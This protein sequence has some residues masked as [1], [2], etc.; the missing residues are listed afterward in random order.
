MKQQSE[1]CSD[2]DKNN[3]SIN[4]TKGE[5]KNIA[6]FPHKI[7]SY[8][9]NVLPLQLCS[10]KEDLTQAPIEWSVRGDAV[11]FRDFANEPELPF[12]N[13]ILLTLMAPGDATVIATLDGVEYSC[14]IT[15][16]PLRH[17]A[18][19]DAT[20]Y[21]VGDM[22]DHTT[23]EH[24]HERFIERTEGFSVDML[25]TMIADGGL[26]FAVISDHSDSSN[27]RDFFRG[28]TDDLLTE[29]KDLIVFP[30]SESEVNLM[31]VDR[32]GVPHKNAG[33]I[34]TL[35]A[36]NMAN[37]PTWEDFFA[38][39]DHSPFAFGILAHP[40]PVGNSKSGIWNFCLDRFRSER[41]RQ[42]IR[43]VEMGDGTDRHANLINEYVYSLSLGGRE[44]D[45]IR[46]GKS[47]M[48]SMRG[49]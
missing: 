39:L 34:V 26:D 5:G 47:F 48:C 3:T 23:T 44:Y 16:T 36:D 21:Y 18:S 8:C 35:N 7:N 45:S 41:H 31:E 17:C 30:G 4:N 43:L 38:A 27:Q 32:Y 40:Q 28:F 42:F 20:E 10:D 24:N 29:P 2:F 12:R 19:E 25:N 9:G 11:S 33:E 37:V 15:V 14:P 6:F 22:H 1:C 49:E 46:T 13:G